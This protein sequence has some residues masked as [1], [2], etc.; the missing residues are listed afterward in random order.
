MKSNLRDYLKTQNKS[1]R[2][3]IFLLIGISG[4][5]VTTI[6][7][8]SGCS[9][10]DQ[11]SD[12]H[13]ETAIEHGDQGL[14]QDEQAETNMNIL[15]VKVGQSTSVS[16]I[17]NAYLEIKNALVEDND[18]KASQA[19]K[20]LLTAFRSMDK[21]TVPQEHIKEINDIIENAQENAE[22]ISE[23]KG[24]IEHQREHFSQ[25]FP[26]VKDL[27]EITGSDRNLYEIYC[28]MANDNEG[29]FWLST[30]DEVQNP[31]MG[32]KMESCGTVK[33]K[34]SIK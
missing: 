14:Q 23:S 26:D 32:S 5:L 7:I 27:I 18:V 6:A 20:E 30:S 8:F 4:L 17:I 28:A 22:H 1:N 12:K 29:G 3:N 16:K 33:A 13:T 31:Y 19:G 9:N 11:N 24:N 21:A 2:K 15:S 25:L 10:V 34:I